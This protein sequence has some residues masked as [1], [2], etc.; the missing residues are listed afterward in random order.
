MGMFKS[1]L[2]IAIGGA[3]VLTSLTG[4]ASKIQYPSYYVLNVP[5]S[6]SSAGRAPA[7]SGAV[8]VREFGA[9]PYLKGGA[10]VYRRSGNEVDFYNYHRWAEH[11]GKTAAAA[12]AGKIQALSLFRSVSLFDGSGIPEWLLTGSID[13]LEEVDQGARVSVEVALSAKLVNV[14]S[15]DVVW[16]GKSSKIGGIEQHSVPGV[17]AEMSRLMTAAID[18]LVTS[19]QDRVAAGALAANQA[20]K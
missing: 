9:P 1:Q 13:Q 2:I 14:R 11:P 10:L 16:Q 17:V 7:L 12:I 15:G 4:C 18:G 8:A 20:S 3:T 19:M 5:A 6:V